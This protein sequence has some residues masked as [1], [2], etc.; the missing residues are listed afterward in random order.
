MLTTATRVRKI[1][2]AGVRRA[3]ITPA[4]AAAAS[5]SP[6]G[7]AGPV[8]IKLPKVRLDIE[9]MKANGTL[10]ERKRK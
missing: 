8:R 10:T 1:L 5:G 4:V 2:D 9:A 6:A 3:G 7:N